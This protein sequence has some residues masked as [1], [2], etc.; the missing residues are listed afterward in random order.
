MTRR[1]RIFFAI[2]LAAVTAAFLY[3]NCITPYYADDYSY[4]FTYAADA[5]KERI[6]NLYE[7]YLSQLNHYKVMNGRAIVHT[8]VQL[9]LMSGRGIFN[10]FNTVVNISLGFAVYFAAHG[11]FRRFR[12]LRLF[13]IYAL[14]WLA[15][16]DY[17]QSCLWLTG[18]INY[19]WTALAALVFLLPYR[20]DSGGGEHKWLRAVG[21]PLLGVLAGWSGENACIA[22]AAGLVLFLLRRK[23]LGL[24]FRLWMFTGAAG[25][26]AGAAALFLSPAQAL[27]ADNM[28]GYGSISTWIS[29]IPSV[30]LHALEYLWLPLLLGLVLLVVS[31]VQARGRGF[32]WWLKRYS[33]AIVW[34]CCAIVSAYCMCAAPYFPLRAWCCAGI[35]AA[36]TVL[37]VYAVVEPPKRRMTRS[38]V[39][40]SCALVCAVCAVTYFFGCS[41]ILSTRAAVIEREESILAQKAAGASDVYAR[42]VTGSSRYNCFTSEPD[43]AADPDNWQNAA[44]A[45]YYGVDH[46]ILDSGR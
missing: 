41:D 2:G 39:Y 28:G 6:T 46:V 32:A 12:P 9:F 43:L 8:L 4:M 30:T 25:F 5:P 23:L 3:L 38:A 13:A 22:A 29:R 20:S 37:S 36:A 26:L 42:G 24:P 1:G 45:L 40:A 33:N 14:I 34:L 19:M 31:I 44:M 17:G 27:K 21:M 16:P 11:T 7:L 15:L 35:L 18:S 10:L